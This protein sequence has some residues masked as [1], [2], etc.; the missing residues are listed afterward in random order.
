MGGIV[1]LVKGGCVGY[2]GKCFRVTSMPSNALALEE[3]EEEDAVTPFVRTLLEGVSPASVSLLQRVQVSGCEGMT[4]PS[5]EG[6]AF[7][8]HSVS[9]RVRR[10]AVR[11]DLLHKIGM[12]A[13]LTHPLSAAS[14]GVTSS[15]ESEKVMHMSSKLL[16]LVSVDPSG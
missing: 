10:D 16:M 12:D 6:P 2:T 3:A 7:M 11:G 9:I 13:C 5:L 15:S 8:G 4:A 14:W 1:A